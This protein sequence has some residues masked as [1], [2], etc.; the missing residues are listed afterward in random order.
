MGNSVA[1]VGYSCQMQALVGQW[2]KLW[3]ASSGT[4]RLAP[5]GIV[6][7]ASSGS[8][9]ASSLAMGAMRQAQTAGFGV[10]PP[11]AAAAP[12][13]PQAQTMM[14]NTFLAQ[15]YRLCNTQYPG[16]KHWVD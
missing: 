12:S 14:A 5:F 11:R 16:Q 8:E 15:A 6:T 4:D 1:Q 2:R 9:G 10:L 3:H 13:A 7:L